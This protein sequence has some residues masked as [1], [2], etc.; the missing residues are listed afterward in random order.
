MNQCGRQCKSKVSMC[1][2]GRK[3]LWF[4]YVFIYRPQFNSILLVLGQIFPLQEDSVIFKC[5]LLYSQ[6]R[7]SQDSSNSSLTER[8]GLGNSTS[9]SLVERLK[10]RYRGD[11]VRL[12][13]KT[14]TWRP[15]TTLTIYWL[16]LLLGRC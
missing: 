13:R 16:C 15:K 4:G 10:R 12:S 5:A 8:R 7:P 9:L 3:G 1:L 2:D 6:L 14:H 11:G